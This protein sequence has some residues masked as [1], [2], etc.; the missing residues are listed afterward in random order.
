MSSK[1]VSIILPAD[2]VE[3]IQDRAT[4]EQRTFS[5]TARL[6][7][8]AVRKWD[9]ATAQYEPPCPWGE[10]NQPHGDECGCDTPVSA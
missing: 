5:Y 3:F 4:A 7:L 10:T 1:N 6:M 9:V 2:L 8:E